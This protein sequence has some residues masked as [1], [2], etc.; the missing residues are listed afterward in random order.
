MALTTQLR[1]KD[2]DEGI[3]RDAK[4]EALL[5]QRTVGD[6]IA[7]ALREYLKGKPRGRRTTPRT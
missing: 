7:A 3:F 1:L 4:V 5:T 2:G 6:V